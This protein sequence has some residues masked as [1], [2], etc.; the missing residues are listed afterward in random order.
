MKQK[1]IITKF[2]NAGKG[3]LLKP[4]VSTWRTHLYN[5]K[6]SKAKMHLSKYKRHF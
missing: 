5:R 6:N 4:K 1:S 3:D 2:G